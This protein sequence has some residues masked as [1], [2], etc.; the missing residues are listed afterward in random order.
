MAYENYK[1]DG[2]NSYIYKKDSGND[3]TRLLA[4][5]KF[6]IEC[7]I[8]KQLDL[9]LLNYQVVGFG[10]HLKDISSIMIIDFTVRGQLNK[11][12]N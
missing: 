3:K 5:I 10:L 12:Y 4:I 11:V 7:N 9:Q 8:K 6:E 2:Y 1:I